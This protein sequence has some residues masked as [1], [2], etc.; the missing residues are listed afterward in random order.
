[1]ENLVTDYTPIAYRKAHHILRNEQ[2]ARDV[3]H[4]TMVKVMMNLEKYNVSWAFSTWV[5]R[6]SR[7][8]AIDLTRK[9]RRLSWSEPSE[10]VDLAL[11]PDELLW[12]E[13]R[14]LLV[15]EGLGELPPMYQEVLRMHHFEE[16][17]YR[18]IANLLDVPIGTV[19]N[20]IHRARK[21]L[22]DQFEQRAA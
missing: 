7:N 11:L 18:E 17:K 9:R 19:M 14:A 21:K 5:A 3:A 6:I 20:R 8:T 2:D 1:M 10:P 4:D 16:L 22:R 12:R 15:H 13:Q